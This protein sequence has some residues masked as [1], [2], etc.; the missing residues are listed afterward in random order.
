MRKDMEASVKV[1]QRVISGSDLR[2]DPA[3]VAELR[4][5]AD[6]V[7]R[8]V[9]PV[10]TEV[11][12]AGDGS[13]TLVGLAAVYESE[14]EELGGFR[15]VIKRG[16]FRR[17]LKQ[18]GLDV[19]CLFNH[20]QNIVLGRTPATLML[21]EDPRGLVYEV[22]VA[23]TTAGNDLRVLLERGDVTQS[24]FA[25]KVGAQEWSEAPDGTLIRTITDFADLLDVSPVT[26]PAY[27]IT[28][29]ESVPNQV[30]SNEPVASRD[31][32]TSESEQGNEGTVEQPVP[33]ADSQPRRADETGAHR[34]RSRRLRLREKRAA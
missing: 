8:R 10:T 20:D 24:S 32:S 31:S 9:A 2:E 26:Y 3:L 22:N 28:S 4:D 29:A 17:V 18:D 12:A 16:A 27:K 14:S 1:E 15:E 19:R 11:R 34:H 33:Q 7:E 6:V 5:G 23:P 25:F 30:S 13:W 21:R